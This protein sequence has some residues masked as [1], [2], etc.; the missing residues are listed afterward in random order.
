MKKPR[1]YDIPCCCIKGDIEHS[2]P[3]STCNHCKFQEQED[4]MP[5][6]S[7]EMTFVETDDK[8]KVIKEETKTIKKIKIDRG[9]KYQE[10]RGWYNLG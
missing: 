7:F 10:I 1:W 5:R 3:V 9:T 6:E 4:S 8:G 2:Y